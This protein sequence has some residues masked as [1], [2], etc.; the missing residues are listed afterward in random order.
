MRIL[1]DAG[2]FISHMVQMKGKK[3]D[4]TFEYTVTFI[5]HMVQMKAD[6][7]V[8]TISKSLT[9]ISHMVQMKVFQQF[10]SL[11]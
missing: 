6:M 9:F 2:H 5:S 11:C 7:R 8:T 4:V 10:Y 1:I 3:D